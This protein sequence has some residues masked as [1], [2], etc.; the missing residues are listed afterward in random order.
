MLFWAALGAA[1]RQLHNEMWTRLRWK[2]KDFFSTGI[3]EKV[4]IAIFTNYE[5]WTRLAGL[6]GKVE[7]RVPCN[8]GFWKLQNIMRRL[9]KILNASVQK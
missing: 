8:L 3:F 4:K 2:S 5:M 9:S 7:T 1:S 6:D